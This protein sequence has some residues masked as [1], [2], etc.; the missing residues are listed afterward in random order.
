LAAGTDE[1]LVELTDARG[2]LIGTDGARRDHVTG[3]F[4]HVIARVE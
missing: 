2:R 3:T 1:P 4:F